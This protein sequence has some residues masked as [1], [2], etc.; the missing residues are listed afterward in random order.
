MD[1]WLTFSLLPDPQDKAASAA[2]VAEVPEFAGDL[3]H[4]L[5]RNPY[6]LLRPH[7]SAKCHTVK[8][9]QN[10]DVVMREKC[11]DCGKAIQDHP[12][13]DAFM[14]RILGLR[15]IAFESVGHAEIVEHR[16]VPGIG[17]QHALILFAR[18]GIESC[19]II[20]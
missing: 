1:Y 9:F 3:I 12:T 11:H 2:L 16:K 20:G 17:R 8:Y 4:R 15:E 18:L 5:A 14:H 13:L 10:V 7:S 19:L 6:R